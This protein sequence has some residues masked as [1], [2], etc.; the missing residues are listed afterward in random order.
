MRQDTSRNNTSKFLD[1]G[2]IGALAVAAS[3]ID[4]RTWLV[5]SYAASLGAYY[6][7]RRVGGGSAC[8]A[9]AKISDMN[10]CNVLGNFRMNAT[11]KWPTVY[12][13]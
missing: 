1:P 7:F 12:A 6:S 4:I 8:N 2:N 11:H 10:K 13:G 9:V 5:V 3:I